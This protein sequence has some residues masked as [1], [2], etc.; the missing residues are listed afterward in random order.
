MN[1]DWGFIRR[2][3]YT[4]EAKQGRHGEICAFVMVHVLKIQIECL[5]LMDFHIR[6]VASELGDGK[7][8]K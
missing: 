2:R 1:A 8:K 7:K 4:N 6:L 3:T 5:G